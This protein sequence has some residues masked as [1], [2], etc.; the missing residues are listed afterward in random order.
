MPMTITTKF[1]LNDLVLIPELQVKGRVSAFRTDA[2]GTRYLLRYF[3]DGELREEW[4]T[5]SEIAP[6]PK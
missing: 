3:Y 6:F 1:N 4:L 2:A 5:D